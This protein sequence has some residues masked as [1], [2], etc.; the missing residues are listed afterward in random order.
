MSEVEQQQISPAKNLIAGGF[1]GMCLVASGHPLDTIKVRLQ[2]MPR[3]VPGQVP[4]YTGALDCAKKIISKEGFLGLYRGMGAPLI[5]VT[6]MY[7]VC[8]GGFA[9]G[10][11]IQFSPNKPLSLSQIFNAGML[12]GLCTT[13]IMAPGN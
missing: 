3:P 5:G 4:L 2:T 12:A 7:M 13:A 6:P 11:M 9:L 10:Q 1:G 8:F